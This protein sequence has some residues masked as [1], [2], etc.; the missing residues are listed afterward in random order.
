MTSFKSIHFKLSIHIFLMSLRQVF[1][2]IQVV[3]FTCLGREVTETKTAESAPCIFSLFYK[4]IF[5]CCYV[6]TQIKVDPLQFQSYLIL[7]CTSIF[8][9]FRGHQENTIQTAPVRALTPEG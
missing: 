1:A 2:E 3:L 4:G 7:I 5:F 8:S 6:Y 9:S